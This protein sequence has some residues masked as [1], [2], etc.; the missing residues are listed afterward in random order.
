MNLNWATQLPKKKEGGGGTF[1]R[2]IILFFC[3]VW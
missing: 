1:E 2:K 3:K